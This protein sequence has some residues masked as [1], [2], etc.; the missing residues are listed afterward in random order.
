MDAMKQVGSY[1]QRA[2]KSARCISIMWSAPDWVA[3]VMAAMT[4]GLTV[5][6]TGAGN[7]RSTYRVPRRQSLALSKAILLT[8]L[9]REASPCLLEWAPA[10]VVGAM[11]RFGSGETL[12]K[13]CLAMAHHTAGGPQL[14]VTYWTLSKSWALT[15]SGQWW[16]KP[17]TNYGE[18]P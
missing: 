14:W 2:P 3:C 6:I 8:A 11:I 13:Y 17:W 12:N 4:E 10:V 18:S 9:G 16:Q 15:P 7:Y 5:C 1:G